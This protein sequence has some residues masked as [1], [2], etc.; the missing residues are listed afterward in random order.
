MI[1]ADEAATVALARA[2]AD[3]LKPGDVIGLSGGL[4]AGKTTLVRY[5]LAAL[6]HEGEVPSPS[7]AIV[8]PYDHVMLGVLLHAD[9]YRIEDPS[10][11]AEIGL[12]AAGEEA[13]LV[14]EWP[15]RAGPAAWP[16][17]LRLTLDITGPESRRLTAQVPAAWEG[18]WPP[19]PSSR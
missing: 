4:G 5:L 7:F 10:E 14:V 12:D 13:V 16:Q 19:T 11:L 18:R 6:G 1:L 9:L 2:L 15:E 3:Q 8:Q 17:A